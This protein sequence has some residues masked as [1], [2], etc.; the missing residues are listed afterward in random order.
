MNVI[1]WRP[2]MALGITEIDKAHQEFFASVEKISGMPDDLL[3]DSLSQLTGK[4]EKDFRREEDLMEACD[5]A[6]IKEHRE[7]HAKLLK[8]LHYV[9]PDVMQGNYAAARR[10]VDV[11]PCW[12][13]MHL[14]TADQAMAHSIHATEQG[15]KRLINCV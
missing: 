3:C 2:E 5:L 9:M 4:L 6:E 13:L 12:Y 10:A 14:S 8:A 15:N 1:T 7:Q 11:L